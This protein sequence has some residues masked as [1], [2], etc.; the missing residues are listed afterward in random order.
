MQKMSEE[1]AIYCL[2]A[3]SESYS[4]V[5]EECSIYGNVGCDHCYNDAID[6][7]IKALEEL[8][9]YKQGGLVLIPADVF[10]RQC[11]EL[12]AYKTIADEDATAETRKILTDLAF[13]EEI[14]KAD[15]V[16]VSK[17]PA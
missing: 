16:L 14:R 7:A 6:M 3:D 17:R 4:E 9:L 2:K 8:N 1:I 10:Q 12:D 13:D 15:F 5:C 11:D